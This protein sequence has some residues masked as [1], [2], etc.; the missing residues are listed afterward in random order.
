MAGAARQTICHRRTR[1]ENISAYRTGCFN[2]GRDLCTSNCLK[3]IWMQVTQFYA[4]HVVIL[5]V[6]S[7][8][9]DDHSVNFVMRLAVVL[10]FS[11]GNF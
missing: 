5:A 3:H 4:G 6:V 1:S 8:F 7:S 11:K 9:G 10:S 2:E